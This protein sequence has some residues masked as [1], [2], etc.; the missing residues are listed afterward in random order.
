MNHWPPLMRFKFMVNAAY[1][2]LLTKLPI[3]HVE[4]TNLQTIPA[5]SMTIKKCFLKKK[6]FS[7]QNR[8]DKFF[9]MCSCSQ[10][11]KEAN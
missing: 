2:L 3:C 1:N 4:E 9:V 5:F 11:Y 10:S 6:L 8:C 7:S